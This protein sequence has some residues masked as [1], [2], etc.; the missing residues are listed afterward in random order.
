MEVKHGAK[1]PETIRRE[2]EV[3]GGM[4]VMVEVLLYVHRNCRFI[5]DGSPESSEYRGGERRGL[6][7]SIAT[8]SP[9]ERLLH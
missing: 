9:P 5:R 7:L 6:Y 1:K 4:E 2:R 8:L 3:G